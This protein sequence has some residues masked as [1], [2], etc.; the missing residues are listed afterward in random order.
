MSMIK[1]ENLTFSYPQ[2][3]EDIFENVSF[4]IDSDWKLGL[5][6]RNGKGKTTLFRLLMQE[7]E[8]SGKITS[9]VIFDYF[10]YPVKDTSQMTLDVLHEVCPQ[11]EDWEFMRE[12]NYLE[13]DAEML[14]RPFE[15]LSN[16]E[17][18][19]VLLA[20]LFLNEGHFLL[21]DEP[22]NHLDVHARQVVSSYLQKKKSFIL[23]SHDRIFVDRC[24]DHILSINKDNIQVANGNY[25]A[26]WDNKQNQDAFEMA[27]NER[28]KK[29]IGR[30]SQRPVKARTGPI[31]WNPR[32]P[33]QP[34]PVPNWIK[35]LSDIRLLK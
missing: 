16:G 5:I 14:Y 15:T 28:L 2:G 23:I 3:T 13:A 29:D 33:V 18:T 7:Y 12:M 9:S 19:K 20:A 1:I 26:W 24:V 34:I 30:L 11:A 27:A 8:Y 22:T 25:S 4:Q 17:Q 32:K 35:V 10:P 31:G 6:G 21:I